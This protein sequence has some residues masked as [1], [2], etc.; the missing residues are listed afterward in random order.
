MEE[1]LWYSLYMNCA[2]CNG[3]L[4]H[5][6][7]FCVHC[8]CPVPRQATTAAEAPSLRL[9]CVEGRDAGMTLLVR[10]GQRLVLG[11]IAG[12]GVGDPDVAEQQVMMLL[13]NGTVAFHGVNGR[14]IVVANLV[15]LQGILRTGEQ[16]RMGSSVWEV[17]GGAAGIEQVIGSLRDRLHTLTDTQALQGFSLREM[18]SEVF[19]NRTD[20][21]MEDY[22]LV[23]T[24]RT[25]PPIQD[26]P[27][28]WPKPWFFMRVLAF[29]TVLYVGFSLTMSQF[30]NMNL[31]PGMILMGSLAI[32]LSTVFLFFELNTPRNVSFPNVLMLVCLGGVASLFTSLLGFSVTNLSWLGASSAGVIEEIGKLLAVIVLVREAR[33]RYTLNGLLFGASVGAGFAVFE[34][35]GYAFNFLLGS[36]SLDVMT[37]VI[38]M[39]ALLSPFG[40]VAWTAIAAGALWRVKGSRPVDFEMFLQPRFWRT[41]AVPVV[42]HMIWNSP[43]PDFLY[44]KFVV[45]GTVAWFVIFALVQQGLRQVR[46]EQVA[47]TQADLDQTQRLTAI[48][49]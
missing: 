9:R 22:F 37:S 38:H 11:Q 5:G 31:I 43:L 27:T 24:S 41:F 28:G 2:N 35:A 19:K 49:A 48:R 47:R 44:L 8:G 14:G 34:S 42:L 30:P 6:S 21:E 20:E 3:A 1:P 25:T 29:V 39:R 13:Q 45:L 12:V 7:R 26:V 33:Y 46:D 36:R 15:R 17:T 10:A 40:H 4:E 18:F 16:F 23:G 32:P